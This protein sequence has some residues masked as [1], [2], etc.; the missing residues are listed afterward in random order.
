[1]KP[2]VSVV[3]PTFRRPDLLQRAVASV[4]RQ[5]HRP[6]ELI[7]VDDDGDDRTAE[8]VRAAM[9]TADCGLQFVGFIQ[10]GG[11]GAAARN[12]GLVAARGRYVQFLDDDDELFPDKLAS[13]V[14]VLE[15]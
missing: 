9:P 1:M 14:A 8:V 10:K 3:I 5:T 13:Q 4:A 11:G 12:V 15:Q 6:I 2:L 7:V